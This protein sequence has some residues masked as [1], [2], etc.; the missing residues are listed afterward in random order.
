MEVTLQD[1]PGNR[2]GVNNNEERLDSAG[3]TISGNQIFFTNNLEGNLVHLILQDHK[4][5]ADHDT[6]KTPTITYQ[7]P[8]LR[9]K[10]TEIR[11]HNSEKGESINY[12]VDTTTING[13]KRD[14]MMQSVVHQN[15]VAD[16]RTVMVEKVQQTQS[17]VVVKTRN[18]GLTPYYVIQK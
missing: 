8:P 14:A 17:H 4:N 9:K 10:H 6:I 3:T 12:L 16:T 1:S 18:D 11:G 2:L 5:T 13:A 15:V 7:L